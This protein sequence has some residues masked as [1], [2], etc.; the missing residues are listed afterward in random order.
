MFHSRIV[1]ISQK[2][3]MDPSKGFV[4]DDSIEL[5]AYVVADA[6]HGIK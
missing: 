4:K 1:Y 5:Q 6:P 3:L 2:E